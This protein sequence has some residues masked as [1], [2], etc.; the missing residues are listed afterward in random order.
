[1]KTIR[2]SAV[3]TIGQRYDLDTL[4]PAGWNTSDHDGYDCWD[5]F[6]AEGTYLGPDEF[7]VE[8]FWATDE[9]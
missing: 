4:V 7:G 8:P 9:R 6:D 5:Y 2:K 1:M 3:L